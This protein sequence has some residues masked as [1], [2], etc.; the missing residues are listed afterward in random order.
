MSEVA[1]SSAGARGL[2]QLMPNTAKQ[3]KRKLKSR[4][5]Y[6]PSLNIKIGTKYFN[7]LLENY[8]NNL[9]YSLAAYNAGESRVNVWQQEY[10]TSDNILKNIENIPFLETR[11]YVKLIFRNIFFYKMILNKDLKDF[12][13]TN[14]IYDIKLGFNG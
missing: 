11:K 14:Q 1:R 6:N 5:L 7:T 8:D 4:Q 13:E 12:S 3:F 10:M 9:V 2:M